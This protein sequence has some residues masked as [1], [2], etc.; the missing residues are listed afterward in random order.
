[1]IGIY[2]E[3]NE[4]IGIGHVMRCLTI[5]DALFSRGQKVIF[6]TNSC[7]SLLEK[8][9][10]QAEAVP[11]GFS[12]SDTEIGFWKKNAEERGLTLLLLDG[13]NVTSAYMEAL[14]KIV[15]TAYLD[16]MCMFPYPVDLVINYNIFADEKDYEGIA[17]HTQLCLG[18]S[19][20]PVRKEFLQHKK[21]QLKQ[22]RAEIL[23][24]VGGADS[25]GLS[26]FIAGTIKEHLEDS[27]LHVLCGPYSRQKDELV[28]LK[29]RYGGIEIY[30]NVTAVWEVMGKC[31][32]AV[33][34]AGT[35]MYEL[36]TMGLPVLTFYFVENQRRIAEG[37]A[38][39][40]AAI[41]VGAYDQ[42][43]P[44][45]FAKR[46][47]TELDRLVGDSVLREQIKRRGTECVDGKGAFRI[48]E[49][50]MNTDARK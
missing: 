3:G 23:I 43:N 35:T 25:M 28:T 13:Y 8:R 27:C 15:K 10:Y 34:A 48:A 19:Y 17:K 9:G 39:E 32:M 29:E 21:E 4:I 18:T 49:A 47:V 12:G 2:A 11:E 22:G 36:A 1:M 31:N 16:D 7:H 40:G 24:S 37:F 42:A 30:E 50:L 5:A 46:L 6:F 38:G 33:S 26:P 44:E 20:A 14:S 41:G 45:A